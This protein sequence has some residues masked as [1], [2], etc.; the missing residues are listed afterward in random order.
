MSGWDRLWRYRV[1]EGVSF[2]LQGETSMALPGAHG[3][4]SK[5]I[6]VTK[7]EVESENPESN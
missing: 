1:L 6:R 5:N 4:S 7:N 2:F 3:D